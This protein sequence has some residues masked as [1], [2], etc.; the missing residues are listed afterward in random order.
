[1]I[2]FYRPG[3]MMGDYRTLH[4]NIKGE[5]RNNNWRS[6]LYQT[7]TANNTMN[8]RAEQYFPGSK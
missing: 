2:M 1:M 8:S 3:F 4:S 7:G 6:V 5:I